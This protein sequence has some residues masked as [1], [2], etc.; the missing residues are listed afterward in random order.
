MGRGEVEREKKKRGHPLGQWS[1]TGHLHLVLEGR[2][3]TSGACGR[4]KF[5][6]GRSQSEVKSPF[7]QL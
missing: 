1:G 7:S 3:Q 2:M 6:R 4:G 5:Q